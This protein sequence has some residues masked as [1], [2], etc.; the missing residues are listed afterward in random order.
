MKINRQKIEYTCPG[1]FPIIIYITTN[2]QPNNENTPPGD[3]FNNWGEGSNYTSYNTKVTEDEIIT[4][5]T[6]TYLEKI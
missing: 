3:S 5:V 2:V 6:E 1:Y 4:I